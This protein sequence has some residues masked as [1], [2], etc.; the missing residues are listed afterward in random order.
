MITGTVD[1]STPAPHAREYLAVLQPRGIKSRM[2]LVSHAGH[3]SQA[4]WDRA[5]AFVMALR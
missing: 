1:E 3:N 5:K 2:S 4:L